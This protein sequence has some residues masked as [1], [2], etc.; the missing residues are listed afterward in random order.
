MFRVLGRLGRDDRFVKGKKKNIEKNT[1]F[2]RISSTLYYTFATLETMSD[3]TK[4]ATA[5]HGSRAPRA[6]RESRHSNRPGFGGSGSRPG[7]SGRAVGDG[8]PR[9]ETKTKSL[10]GK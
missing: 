7:D 2:N 8:T 6:T 9:A 3:G 4:V 10:D 1:A 5:A